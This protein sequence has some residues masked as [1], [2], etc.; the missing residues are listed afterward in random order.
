[1]F[2]PEKP[3]DYT[4]IR[5]HSS[6]VRS[7]A[8][9]ARGC[10]TGSGR[11]SPRCSRSTSPTRK[12]GYASLGFVYEVDPATGQR[13]DTADRVLDAADAGHRLRRAQL[14]GLPHGDLPRL[15]RR[16]ADDRAGDAR[17]SARPAGL[18]QVPLRL[19][20]RRP[21]HGRQ[22]DG[23]DGRA[24]EARAGRPADL[25]D[26]DPPGAPGDAPGQI[27]GPLHDRSS[28]GAGP[29]RHVHAVQDA[30]LRLSRYLGLLGGQRRLPLDLEPAESARGC[31]CTG[32]ATT[33]RCSSG[34]SAPPWAPARRPSRSTCPG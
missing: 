14:L 8:R 19:R 27:A 32:T 30:E 6:T 34:T 11:S 26:R 20:Q 10:P 15:A 3:V 18:F 28:L 23:G 24:A 13:R 22:R 31:R 1:M 21:V 5:E 29:D 17:A 9:R 12:A 7:A 4:D 33:P 16:P 25:L 2:V